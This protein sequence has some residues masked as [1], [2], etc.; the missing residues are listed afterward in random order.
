MDI[1]RTVT[2]PVNG[3]TVTF[4]TLPE[5]T[6]G[7]YLQIEVTGRAGTR[8]PPVHYHP[9]SV[10]QFDV[11]EGRLYLTVDGTEH[12][13]EAGETFVVPAR[14]PHTYRVGSEAVRSVTTVTPPGRFAEF[15]TTEYALAHAGKL[16]AGADG[17]LLAIAPWIHEFR[18]VS[19]P[20]GPIGYVFRA[21][22]PLGR[23][24]GNPSMPE[25]PVEA[26]RDAKKIA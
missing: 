21:L 13:V 5:E 18:D 24:L 8:G 3:T 14:V 12:A 17:D 1:P 6:G 22:A 26:A 15:L 7:E 11:L 25:Y 23:A 4:L 2:D 20:V 10:E 19:R 9:T 16:G